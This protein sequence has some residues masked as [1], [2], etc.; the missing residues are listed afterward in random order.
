MRCRI[1]A[2]YGF[3]CSVI[4]TLGGHA[5]LATTHPPIEGDGVVVAAQMSSEGME[6][7]MH[8]MRPDMAPPQGVVGGMSPRKGTLMVSLQY[9]QMRMDGNRDGTDD[10]STQEV[11]AQYPIAP[12]NMDMDMFMVGGMYGISNRFSIMGM[13]P[14]VWKEMDHVTRMGAEFTTESEGFGDIRLVPAYDV[15]KSDRDTVK[16]TFGLSIPVGSIDERDETPAGPNQP[17]P[18]PMQIGSGTWDL[19]PGATYTARNADWSWGGQVGAVIR[20]SENDRDYTFGDIYQASVWGARKWTDWLSTSLRLQGEIEGDVE[21]SDSRLNPLLVPTADP[22][23]RA[24]ERLS[25]GLGLNFIFPSG[26]LEG[27]GLAVEGIIPIYQNLDG[28]Q[29]ERDYVLV[30]GLRKAF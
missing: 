11:L 5:S 3:L 20:L 12:L 9:M 19:M 14:Y 6:S 22:D 16:L 10:V 30:F 7:E 17:L 18:Y 23:L 26:P 28:P 29:I 4:V 8:M 1:V 15:Y 27:L 13:V 24:G 2:S 21:G 25:V